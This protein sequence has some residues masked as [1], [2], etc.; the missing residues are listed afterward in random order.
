MIGDNR[1]CIQ[2]MR[3][4]ARPRLKE[5]VTIVGECKALVRKLP[6]RVMF[7]HVKREFNREADFLS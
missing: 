2:F 5:L 7:F 3:G 1:L 4:E 6:C